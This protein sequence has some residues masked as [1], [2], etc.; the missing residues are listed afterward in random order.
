M[1]KLNLLFNSK[2]FADAFGAA[3][4]DSNFVSQPDATVWL[5]GGAASAGQGFSW[6][7]GKI[8]YRGSS[9]GFSIS[10]LS[11]ADLPPVN[12]SATGIVKR[13]NALADFVGNYF[14]AAAE[15]RMTAGSSANCLRNDRGVQIQ[16]IANDAGLRFR[17][18][19]NGVRISFKS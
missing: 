17:A 11:I 19:I 10:G 6:D 12:T 9:H 2:Q 13:L 4:R 14:A 18:S 7:H 8:D 15:G 5:E 16:L 1:D 3:M